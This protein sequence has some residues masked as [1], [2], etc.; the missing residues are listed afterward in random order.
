MTSNA[1][2][3]R[4]PVVAFSSNGQYVYLAWQDNT[5]GNY[6]IYFKRNN[7]GV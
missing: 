6:E 2:W 7:Y 5:L 3:S 1:G 4:E